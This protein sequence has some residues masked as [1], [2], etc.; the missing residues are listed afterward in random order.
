MNAK[1]IAG[2]ALILL[3][4]G[5]AGGG[6]YTAKSFGPSKADPETLCPL[7]GPRHIT[8]VIVDKTDPLTPPEQARARQIVSAERAAAEAG[9]RIA[10]KL[11]KEG[12]G[13][14][15]AS[16]DTIVD[17]CN[18]GAHANPFFENPRRVAARY[19]R[20][21]REPIDAALAAFEDARSASA[22]PIAGALEL[23]MSEMHAAPGT[24]LKLIL[25]S[26]LMENGSDASAY[27][28]GLTDRALRRT[29]SASANSLFTGARVQVVLLPRPRYD[30]QQKAALK[31]WRQVLLD[32]TGREPS[33]FLSD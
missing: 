7:E 17:L 2:A 21:F 22:S 29:M 20:A 14:G 13:P 10:V 9:D 25:I 12:D 32:L 27:R 16:L 3:S 15:R 8:L 1:T 33:V 28:G 30:A 18:P 31:A 19:E 11:I 23:A 6:L 5:L 24:P 4:A 26:D